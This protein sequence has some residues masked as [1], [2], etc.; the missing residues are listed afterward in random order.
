MELSPSSGLLVSMLSSFLWFV[1]A[2]LR[3]TVWGQLACWLGILNK[4]V[5]VHVG[6]SNSDWNL[7]D[8]Q[9]QLLAF[10]TYLY[11]Q[12]ML[13]RLH[14]SRSHYLHSTVIVSMVVKHYWH[15]ESCDCEDLAFFVCALVEMNVYLIPT[16]VMCDF[17][18]LS[19]FFE[20]THFEVLLC[21]FACTL[22]RP[23]RQGGKVYLYVN[24]NWFVFVLMVACL[25]E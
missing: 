5:H 24:K 6:W 2:S 21:R 4:H 25:L 22:C 10:C 16:Q 3:S 9:Q 1:L 17:S 19:W 11:S 12:P 20:L 18:H 7:S 14:L 8:W 23:Q 13:A 15:Y